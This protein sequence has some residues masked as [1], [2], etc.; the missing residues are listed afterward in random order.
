[1]ADVNRVGGAL[2]TPINVTW[3]PLS[4][5]SIHHVVAT[6][7]SDVGTD[8]AENAFYVF[9]ATCDCYIK[10]GVAAGNASAGDGSMMVPRGMPLLLDAAQGRK[11]STLGL[12]AGVA[13][14]QRVVPMV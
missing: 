14:L 4:A 8:M 12:T 11:L 10:Q 6:S 1:M 5:T 2:I 3:I 9:T 7:E 13:T